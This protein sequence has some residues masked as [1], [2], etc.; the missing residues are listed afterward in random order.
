MLGKK[1]LSQND[2]FSQLYNFTNSIVDKQYDSYNLDDTKVLSLI[3]I[4]GAI[5][6]GV[7][8]FIRLI[9]EP[10]QMQGELLKQL[11]LLSSLYLIPITGFILIL[12]SVFSCLLYIFPRFDS[13]IGNY[14][15]P[16][17]MS[18]IIKISNGKKDEYYNEIIKTSPEKMIRHNCDQIV[19]MCINN[20]KS[21]ICI[22]MGVWFS[23]I[24]VISCGIELLFEESMLP[25]KN[26]SYTCYVYISI[27][28]ILIIW[29]LVIREVIRRSIDTLPFPTVFPNLPKILAHLFG[30]PKGERNQGS[31]KKEMPRKAHKKV[32]PIRVNPI[33]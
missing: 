29:A 21:I 19:G 31:D 20:I 5:I 17:T 15:N 30:Q 18:G 32:G 10:S 2:R 33:H 26:A 28:L 4:N 23:G 1:M 24:G 16:R 9:K 22:R 12:F 11:S 27:A 25:I 3:A 8:A 6:A 7:L 14:A 13:K